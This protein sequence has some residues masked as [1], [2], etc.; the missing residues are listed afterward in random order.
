M[1]A[2]NSSIAAHRPVT[3]QPPPNPR[4]YAVMAVRDTPPVPLDS[5]LAPGTSLGVLVASISYVRAGEGGEAK[6]K[7][8]DE[9]GMR[10]GEKIKAIQTQAQA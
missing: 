1:A 3:Y 5:S 2:G 6:K 7:G 8:R 10:K 9:K 4:R